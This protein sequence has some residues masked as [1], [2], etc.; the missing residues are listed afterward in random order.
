MEELY[1]FDDWMMDIYR[2]VQ[3]LYFLSIFFFF[4]QFSIY[5]VK[6]QTSIINEGGWLTCATKEKVYHFQN[7]RE[8]KL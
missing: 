7:M 6:S 3:S 2:N 5:K 1:Q 8:P 4:A